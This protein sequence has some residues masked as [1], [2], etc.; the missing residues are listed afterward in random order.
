MSPKIQRTQHGAQPSSDSQ[1]GTER[2]QSTE[3]H[4]P[5]WASTPARAAKQAHRQEDWFWVRLE[6]TAEQPRC[7]GRAYLPST[8]RSSQWS[9]SA[10]T[11]QPSTL[12]PH[13]SYESVAMLSM[14]TSD[15]SFPTRLLHLSTCLCLAA[16]RCKLMAQR[17]RRQDPLLHSLRPSRGRCRSNLVPKP[18]RQFQNW[19]SSRR[20]HLPGTPSMNRRS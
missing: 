9:L 5:V 11:G 18:T 1:R 10:A 14:P 6:T 13:L 8:A 15:A 17:Q 2:W 4:E 12:A 20:Y 3:E 16:S 7:P 19:S